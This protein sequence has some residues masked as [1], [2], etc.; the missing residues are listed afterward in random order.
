MKGDL[1]HFEHGM[2][3]LALEGWFQK[4]LEIA[5]QPSVGFTEN[6]PKRQNIQ[7]EAVPWVS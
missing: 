1:D 6:C 7:Q 4:L 5:T 2:R 3:S